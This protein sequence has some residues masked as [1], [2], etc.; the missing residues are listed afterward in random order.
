MSARQGIRVR[1]TPAVGGHAELWRVGA[2]KLADLIARRA[3]SSAEVTEALVTR[4]ALL[5]PAL[6][7]FTLFDP[8]RALAAARRVDDAP[9]GDRLLAGVPFA[10]KDIFDI[11]GAPTRAGSRVF[12]TDRA[13]ATAEAVATLEAAGLV[14]LGKL[15]TNELGAG[16]FLHDAPV[17]PWRGDVTTGVS[18]AG[19]GAALAAG[20]IPLALGADTGGSARIPAAFCGVVGLRPTT[21]RIGL[22]G[23]VGL[24]P[25]YDTA[26]PMARTVEDV[27]MLLRCLIGEPAAPLDLDTAARAS[28]TVGVPATSLTGAVDER[29]DVAMAAAATSFAELGFRVR[30][31]ELPPLH[32]ADAVYRVLGYTDTVDHHREVLDGRWGDLS[33]RLV[34]RLVVGACLSGRDVA[35]ARAS[36]ATIRAD[37]ARV[38]QTVDVVLT[39][40]TP[41]L[42]DASAV[43]L[44]DDNPALISRLASVAGVPAIAFPCGVTSDG[45]PLSVQLMGRPRQEHIVLLV[46]R[47]YEDATPWHALVPLAG[48]RAADAVAAATGVAGKN[49]GP[50]GPGARAVSER[51]RIE[52]IAPTPHLVAAAVDELAQVR[53]A[54]TRQ[55]TTNPGG[56]SGG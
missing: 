11:A 25:I 45:L 15:S 53:R 27:A 47:A 4:I 49:D 14:P 33:E 19:A 1:A 55:R 32:V 18:S 39:P 43:G 44:R 41:A 22:G 28:I 40:S 2:A 38:L 17:N 34:R 29:V 46:A 3:V 7:A 26:A 9:R 56:R 13:D 5:D 30:R 51:L 20:L 23:S 42:A 48:P 50:D 6:R 54:L 31:V 21:G 35:A 12:G 24:S 36:G 52:G 10:V 8:D 16:G 37:L